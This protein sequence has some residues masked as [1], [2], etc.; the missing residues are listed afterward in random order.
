M[1][2]VGDDKIIA[3]YDFRRNLGSGFVDWFGQSFFEKPERKECELILISSVRFHNF[4]I[5][6]SI[7]TSIIMGKII[8]PIGSIEQSATKNEIVEMAKKHASDIVDKDY[9]LLKVFV[10]LKRYDL[11]LNTI[12]D[13]LKA[14]SAEKAKEQIDK[15]FEYANA[16]IT[17]ANF[18]KY[19]F[20]NDIKW[21]N[22]KD[23]MDDLK[24][25][26]KDREALLK[27][28]EKDE[29]IVN[30]ETGEI[31]ILKKP[32]VEEVSRIIVRL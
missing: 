10:E 29:E 27:S 19:N 22:I 6:Q 31:E 30:E 24:N 21:A 1:H 2:F 12:I 4:I 20:E 23:E 8:K 7:E 17:V 13:E 32:E 18:K 9:D 14:A 28:L 16:K 11:Y 15:T 3:I 26:K 25:W 5:F